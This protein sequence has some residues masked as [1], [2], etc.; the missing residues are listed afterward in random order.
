MEPLPHTHADDVF[1]FHLFYFY[2][3][4]RKTTFCAWNTYNVNFKG[5]MTSNKP[6]WIQKSSC[7]NQFALISS[8]AECFIVIVICYDYYYFFLLYFSVCSLARSLACLFIYLLCGLVYSDNN[9]PCVHC[10]TCF[11]L[12]PQFG[13]VFVFIVSRFRKF[14]IDLKNSCKYRSIC[15][16]G[17]PEISM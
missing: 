4:N 17:F 7:P 3:S 16:V 12:S 8:R 13:S 15:G 6:Q 10:T 2:F 11:L 9:S 5:G 1:I 14:Y